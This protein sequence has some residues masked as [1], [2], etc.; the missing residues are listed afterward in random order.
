MT[1]AP[2]AA[3]PPCVQSGKFADSL[4]KLWPHGDAHVPGLVEG[5]IAQALTA[6]AKWGLSSD[7]VVAHAMAEF[8]EECGAGFDMAE[9]MNYTAARLLQVFPTHFNH[10]QAIAMAHQPRLIADQ[11]YGSRMGNKAGTDDG[12]NYRG[13][14]LSQLTGK[15]NYIAFAQK[16][17]IDVV[18]HP[19]FLVSPDYA[20]E[21]GIA[22]FVMCGCLPYALRDNLVGVASLL[23]V[24][25]FVSDPHKINGYAMR[26]NWLSLWKHALGV[27]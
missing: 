23:N 9:N 10:D 7:L 2:Q 27:S 8:S 3:N 17:G 15:S 18:T 21:C 14:G 25:H 1:D 4:K 12:W 5:M 19:E 11:A 6:F 22:D 26:A 13:Q 24:G 20:L 16:T